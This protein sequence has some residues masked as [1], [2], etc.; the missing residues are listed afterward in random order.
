MIGVFGHMGS[1][2]KRYRAILNHLKI[3]L[4]GYDPNGRY[5]SAFHTFDQVA[6]ECDRFIIATP[7]E[8][9]YEIVMRLMKYPWSDKKPILI[10]KPISKNV[11]E[12]EEILKLP[13]PITMQYQYSCLPM[14]LASNGLSYYDYYNT[15]KD[16]LPWDCLQIIGLARSSVMLRNESPVWLCRING[17]SMYHARMDTAYIR[18]VEKWLENPNFQDRSMVLGVHEKVKNFEMNPKLWL[19]SLE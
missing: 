7:T 16:G 14:D 8:S 9:H 18:F 17:E 19:E 1:M 5:D 3:P 4:I 10:E 2:G 6:T 15:G 13:C 12:A 11:N